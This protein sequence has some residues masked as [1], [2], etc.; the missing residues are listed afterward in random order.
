VSVDFTSG[1]QL[2]TVQHLFIAIYTVIAKEDQM[3]SGWVSQL[4]G[5]IRDIISLEN[6][7]EINLTIY[8]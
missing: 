5:D 1:T 4:L 8:E 7:Y 6:K 2:T 3:K